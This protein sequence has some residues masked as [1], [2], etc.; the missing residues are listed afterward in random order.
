MEEFDI[1]SDYETNVNLRRSNLVIGNRKMNVVI[2][3]NAFDNRTLKA[4]S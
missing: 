4:L 2:G 1:F 3:R